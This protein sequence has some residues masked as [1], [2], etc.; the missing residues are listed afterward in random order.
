[1]S[2]TQFQIDD[3]D[4]P[5][6]TR[7]WVLHPDIR[8][9][10]DRRDPKPAL[11]EAVS[12]ARALPQLKFVGADVVPLRSV[13]AGM[14]FG[15]GKIKEVH[16]LLEAAEVE[17]VLVDGPVSP[18][19]QRNLEKAWGVKL[20]DR[21]GLILEIF[22]DRAATRE[23]VLQ[24]EMAALNYQR[25]RLVR[26][27][28]HLERQRGGLGFV[29]GPGETQIEADR[30][31][32]DEQLVRLRRQLEKVVKTRALHR[33]ARAKVPY[34]IVAL[35]GYTN[36]GKSTLFNRLTGAEVMAKDMLFA[37]LDPTMRSLVLPDGPEIIL[38]DTVGFI[39]DLPTELVAAFRATL[40]EVLAAD[41]I[42]HVRDISH[43][44]TEEQARDVL[45]ILTSLGVPE[46]TRTFEIWN[47]ID[48][49]TPE[50]ADAM[51]QRAERDENVLAISAITGEGLEGLQAAVAEALQG[52]VRDADLTLGFAEGKK[53]A[54]L[55]A[56]DVVQEERQTDDGFEL[57]VRWSAQQ[58]AQFQRL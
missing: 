20:L 43:A 47:K 37:T 6:V 1:M 28:T 32:I 33:A 2:R 40:E 25:T 49:L 34:P 30:R 57:T 39:S 8:S 5:R 17:L 3:T 23:G 53:R 52:A 21:T 58:E 26:A 7:A 54:W 35:V 13:S 11:E 19:Q 27:W 50:A 41:I 29:G 42:C 15:S 4:G 22:S 9:N 16:D 48:Q 12:L 36:A 10:P 38:S 45:E 24:V 18:V 51:R 31:A 46:E 56:Q 44:E 14:L 55:F